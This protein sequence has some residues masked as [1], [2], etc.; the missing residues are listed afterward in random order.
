MGRATR[1][2]FREV[3]TGLAAPYTNAVADVIDYGRRGYDHANSV[4]VGSQGYRRA[5]G[6]T[7]VGGEF[8]HGGSDRVDALA[9]I[10]VDFA[11]FRDD[12]TKVAIEDADI[13][14]IATDVAPALAE[15]QNFVARMASSRLAS[16]VTKWSVFESWWKRLHGLREAARSRGIH[17]AS[18][19]PKPLPQT[20]WQRGESGTGTTFDAWV[21]LGRKGIFGALTIAGLIGLYGMIRRLRGDIRQLKP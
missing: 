10:G 12:V 18:P 16:Y 21:S 4:Y 13:R 1:W 6:T 20:I 15:W 2:A 3:A 19:D 5:P 14:W 9:Q 8:S 7:I 11:A 17:L